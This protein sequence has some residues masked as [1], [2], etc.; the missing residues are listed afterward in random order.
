MRRA[1]HF[2]PCPRAFAQRWLVHQ[3]A[4]AQGCTATDA[5][6][7]LVQLRQAEPLG[8]VDDHDAGVR[9]VDTDFD[10][11]R[12][13]QQ[14]RDAVLE[15]AH[16]RILLGRPQAAV[17]EAD[18]QLRQFLAQLPIRLLRS[19]RFELIVLLDQRADPV[20]LTAGA[21]GVADAREHLGAAFVRQRDGLHRCAA[22][23]QF[24]DD[25]DI[26]IGVDGLRQRA[27]N[28]CRRHD[29]L[30]RRDAG[31]PLVAQRQPLTD[32]E[33]MLL[34]DHDKT[35]LLEPHV[36]LKHRVRADPDRRRAARCA[37]HGLVLLGFLHPARQHADL[38]TQRAEPAGQRARVLLDQQFRR[39]HQHRLHAAHCAT[40]HRRRR[41]HGLAGTDIALD[42]SQHRPAGSE[43]VRDLADDAAL[44]AGQRERQFFLELRG[45]DEHML[46]ART[47]RGLDLLAQQPHAE[48]VR[49]QFFADQAQLR[50]MTF[51]Q[52]IAEIAALRLMQGAQCAQRVW[53]HQA[54]KIMAVVG[55]VL[56]DVERLFDQAAQPRLGEPGG[57]RIDR[58]Q[59]FFR[60]QECGIFGN[61]IFGM[62][63]LQPL[64]AQ[65]HGAEGA[66]PAVFRERDLLCFVEMEEA[67]QETVLA[68]V[69]GNA[70]RALAGEADVDR[71]DTTADQR[72][73][74]RFH[75][76]QW[77][78]AATVL[79]ARRQVQ[80]EILH[81]LDAECAQLHRDGRA[82]TFEKRDLGR[83]RQR[84][85]RT[86][87][88]LLAGIKHG[89]AAR[90]KSR[91]TPARG[92]RRL[93]CA[94]RAAGSPRQRRR[95]PGRA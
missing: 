30:M 77:H 22:R 86:T 14:L 12:R 43:V 13:D 41:D 8:V 74:A 55:I 19:L 45:G 34:V 89:R 37:S 59:S 42:Q 1:H 16:L 50:R 84:R 62:H 70:Q 54:R 38:H 94:R 26:E 56:G 78:E 11:R 76:V 40:E 91:L 83:Q 58:R 82:G 51:E 88:H 53:A 44:R 69:D 80:Q 21:A 35:E 32:T 29:E 47:G 66:H 79:V 72:F 67:Q 49:E 39:R 2:E 93:P 75:F 4:L 95:A 81:A 28:R 61:A 48:L 25:A 31:R 92:P 57:E 68:V 64:R 9:H 52:Q 85:L 17:Y 90:T 20:G 36:A 27:W 7:Q 18:T 33:A 24:V 87:A 71:H 63:H 10:D 46:D 73:V 60:R 23:R 15:R 6:A 3:Q 65:A 5:A